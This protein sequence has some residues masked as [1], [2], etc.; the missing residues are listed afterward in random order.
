MNEIFNPYSEFTIVYI[1]DV[2]IFSPNLEQ[3]YKHLNIFIKVIKQNGR[4]EERRVGKE[5]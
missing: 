3:H 5:C 2:L 4:S 1:Y